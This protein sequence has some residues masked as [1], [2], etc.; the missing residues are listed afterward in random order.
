MPAWV[1]QLSSWP[2]SGRIAEQKDFERKLLGC[3][4]HYREGK[5]HLIMILCCGHLPAL[6][7]QF[8]KVPI[9]NIL[10]LFLLSSSR[11]ILPFPNLFWFC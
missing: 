3:S 2:L 8:L 4:S 10:L 5:Q 7:I 1:P 9:K 11:F 6:Q